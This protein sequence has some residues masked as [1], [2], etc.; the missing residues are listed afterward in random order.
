MMVHARLLAETDPDEVEREALAIAR[1]KSLS[2]DSRGWGMH[3]LGLMAAKRQE[4]R[5][6]LRM[7][8]ADADVHVRN[9]S[10]YALLYA[11]LFHEE[12]QIFVKAAYDGTDAAFEGLSWNRDPSVVALM[13][14]IKSR[15][16]E[17]RHALMVRSADEVLKRQEILG[18]QDAQERLASLVG[19]PEKSELGEW[20]LRVVSAAP[21]QR[22]L[23]SLRKR[24]DD[25]LENGRRKRESFVQIARSH[26]VD[27]GNQRFEELYPTEVTATLIPDPSY[28]L[29]L[30]IYWRNGGKVSD[31]EARRLSHFGYG[32]DPRVRLAE[33]LQE[34]R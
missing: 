3:V 32:C 31:L 33:L 19:S 9:Y 23:D 5:L 28:D 34:T 2:A 4:S 1:D 30:L 12:S 14:E 11:G 21:G 16:V 24:L 18:S 13:M 10:L 15:P 8:A 7:L 17:K 22:I 20:A 6:A 26:D 29:A 27:P 25:S